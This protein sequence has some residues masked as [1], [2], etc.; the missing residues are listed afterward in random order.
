MLRPARENK[1]KN[2][3]TRQSVRPVQNQRS[4]PVP[5]FRLVVLPYTSPA[6]QAAVALSARP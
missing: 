3:R 6:R 2:H 4:E 5:I 1:Q